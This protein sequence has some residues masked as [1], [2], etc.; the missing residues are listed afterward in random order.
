M[1]NP[2]ADEGELDEREA[3]EIDQAVEDELLG[4]PAMTEAVSPAHPATGYATQHPASGSSQTP[5]GISPLVHQTAKTHIQQ[6]SPF[7]PA[8][9][10]NLKAPAGTSHGLSQQQPQ[11]PQF[12]QL[13]QQQVPQQDLFPAPQRTAQLTSFPQTPRTQLLQTHLEQQNFQMMQ[14]M[15]QEQDSKMTSHM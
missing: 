12:S 3:G 1:S 7:Q 8:Q 6:P 11:V 5:T 13:Q 9:Q 2:L 10:A 15:Q 4:D 14:R